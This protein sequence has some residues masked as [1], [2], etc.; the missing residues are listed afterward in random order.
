MNAHNETVETEEGIEEETRGEVI[1]VAKS[2]VETAI[3]VESVVSNYFCLRDSFKKI[4][5]SFK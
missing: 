5:Y 3:D 4:N 1:D 2:D